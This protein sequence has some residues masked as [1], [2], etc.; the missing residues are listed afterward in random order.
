MK[1]RDNRGTLDDTGRVNVKSSDRA[2]IFHKIMIW[3]SGQL[4]FRAR[5]LATDSQSTLRLLT[6]AHGRRDGERR[7]RK[8]ARARSIVRVEIARSARLRDR[9][10]AR[11][12][13]FPSPSTP[14]LRPKT[15][16]SQL[17]GQDRGC[18][19]ALPVLRGV[20][21]LRAPKRGALGEPFRLGST[22]RSTRSHSA[23]ILN[24]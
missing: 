24:R 18:V 23:A 4:Q 16:P 22:S 15:P 7:G 12:F 8:F 10:R 17:R 2:R 9:R 3:S 11:F 5:E 14:V 21:V 20:A 6:A 13:P 19:F 1:S